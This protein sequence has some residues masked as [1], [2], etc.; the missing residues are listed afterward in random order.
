MIRGS[1][2]REEGKVPVVGGNVRS[3]HNKQQQQQQK[4]QPQPRRYYDETELAVRAIYRDLLPLAPPERSGEA[5]APRPTVTRRKAT[6]HII[7]TAIPPP[8]TR[9]IIM[10]RT[11]TINHQRPI[12]RSRNSFAA[13]SFREDATDQDGTRSTA[14][15]SIAKADH[16]PLVAENPPLPTATATAPI[17][18]RKYYYYYPSDSRK[19]NLGQNTRGAVDENEPSSTAKYRSTTTR[20]EE[21]DTHQSGGTSHNNSNRTVVAFYRSG[22]MRKGK[23]PFR[24]FGCK[25]QY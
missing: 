23:L 24:V 18:K 14:L 8:L 2:P 3:W 10:K 19:R 12:H 15:Q 22:R 17:N 16:D 21:D 7:T 25:S 5:R 4:Q 9:Q 20:G 13:T 1:Q 11:M 6:I